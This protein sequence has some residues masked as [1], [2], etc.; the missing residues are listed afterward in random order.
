MSSLD[1]DRL[2]EILATATAAGASGHD[3]RIGGSLS[4][5]Y[6]ARTRNGS[7]ALLVPLA[8]PPSAAARRAGGFLLA[9]W[10]SIEFAYDGRT[11]TQPAAVLECLDESMSGPF[12]VLAADIATRLRVDVAARGW[13]EV[14]A[15]VD[16][17][18][19]LLSPRG[20]LGSDRES[21]LWGELWFLDQAHDRDRLLSA[22][23]GPERAAAD[24]VLGGVTAE[25][26]VSLRR[27]EHHVSQTQLDRPAGDYES[28]VLSVWLGSD[29]EHGVALPELVNRLLAGVDDGAQLLRQLGR[30][31]YAPADHALYATRYVV[32]EE[33]WWV[34][35]SNVPRV[36]DADPGISQLRYV[37]TLSDSMRATDPRP[38]WHHFVGRAPTLPRRGTDASS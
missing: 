16:E 9:P 26:K 10:E 11:W 1:I 20:G 31:G 33:P 27:H 23:R 25:V 19:S 32:L 6:L 3:Y 13:Q 28:Y 34:P 36:R 29:P 7:A 15:V 12:L 14:L 22:W 18:Q 35:V 21:G 37:V 17:W 5:A 2:R 30:S 24:F 4:G 8:E 38:L